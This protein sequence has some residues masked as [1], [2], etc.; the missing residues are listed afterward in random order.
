MTTNPCSNHY[1]P[2]NP[3]CCVSDTMNWDSLKVVMVVMK[4][5]AGPAKAELA[6]ISKSS[7]INILGYSK[8]TS[9]S[10]VREV[11]GNAVGGTLTRSPFPITQHQMQTLTSS[12]YIWSGFLVKFMVPHPYGLLPHIPSLQLH[13]VLRKRKPKQAK[14]S[15]D[16][17]P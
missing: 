8:T 9:A 5:W 13:L 7:K 4:Y 14:L 10:S 16:R 1:I 3:L 2:C 11:V 6:W 12:Y 15:K 17:V